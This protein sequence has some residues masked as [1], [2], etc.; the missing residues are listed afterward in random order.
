MNVIICVDNNN[1]IMFNHRRQSRDRIVQEH[2]LA[3]IGSNRLW[4]NSYSKK[5]F[6]D[7]LSNIVV[8]ENY[9]NKAGKEDYCFVEGI[10]ISHYIEKIDKII[11]FKWNRQY[12]ADE[13]FAID[14]SQWILDEFEEFT[15]QSHDI[16]KE[17]Y[18]K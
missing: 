9:L 3:M 18:K 10:D 4:M 12:P 11:L 7:E 2:I 14:L 1:G 15:G 5:L 6:A 17:I 8:D 13:F 16:T